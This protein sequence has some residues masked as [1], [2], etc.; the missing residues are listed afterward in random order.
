M[1]QD[2]NSVRGA[3]TNYP[4]SAADNYH[5]DMRTTRRRTQFKINETNKQ[6]C[7]LQVQ[8]FFQLQPFDIVPP[9]LPA[10]VV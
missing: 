4:T 5:C 1:S 6:V 9:I 8:V 10:V 7:S 2:G 3:P